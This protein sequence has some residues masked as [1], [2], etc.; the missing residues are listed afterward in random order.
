MG[1]IP[2]C[3]N[4]DHDNGMAGCDC[5]GGTIRVPRNQIFVSNTLLADNV[6]LEKVS[7]RVFDLFPRF[8]RIGRCELRTIKVHDIAPKMGV[9]LTQVDLA[10]RVSPL[11]L[12]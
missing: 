5:R 3:E 10:I 9:G 6:V 1:K 4:V 2:S 12:E 11:T 7:N 8:Y